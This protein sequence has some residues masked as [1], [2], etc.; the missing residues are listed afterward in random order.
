MR[1]WRKQWPACYE[2]L[3][4]ELRQRKPD[5]QGVREFLEIL[6]LH[7]AYPQQQIEQAVKQALD[8]GAAHLDGVQLCLRQLLTPKPAI[9]SRHLEVRP[10]LNGIGRQPVDLEQYNQLLEAR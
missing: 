6:Q 2:Q 1:R 9:R 3:L 10:E 7:Q 5:G 4:A 8:C